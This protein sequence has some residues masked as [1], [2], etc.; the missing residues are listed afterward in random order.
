MSHNCFIAD[1]STVAYIFSHIQYFISYPCYP[2]YLLITFNLICFLFWI[3][4]ELKIPEAPTQ[5]Y[6]IIT[7]IVNPR[8]SPKSKEQHSS[9]T[10]DLAL[11]KSF[12]AN[13][14]IWSIVLDLFQVHKGLLHFIP[15]GFENPDPWSISVVSVGLLI[16]SV[17][18]HLLG[19]ANLTWQVF[20]SHQVV[21]I[22][23]FWVLKDSGIW[24]LPSSQTF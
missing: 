23:K 10:L 5:V 18:T 13:F 19:K 12:L 9:A 6:Y 20:P 1:E 14:G 3:K 16:N 21:N 17:L 22:S 2:H 15:S 7:L 8:L 4:W 11:E 24:G